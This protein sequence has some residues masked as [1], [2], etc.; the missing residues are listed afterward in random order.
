MEEV[1]RDLMRNQDIEN[2]TDIFITSIVHTTDNEED[3]LAEKF[4]SNDE[5]GLDEYL[6]K[7]KDTL[8]KSSKSVKNKEK[9]KI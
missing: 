8:K 1:K 9:G 6:K 2:T 4:Q 7:F 3:I 5:L